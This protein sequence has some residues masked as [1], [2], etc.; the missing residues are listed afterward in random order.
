MT[1]K[2]TLTILALLN[3][4]YAGGKND[5]KQQTEAW[6]M[7]LHKYDYESA[8]NAVLNFAENDTRDYATFPA[9]GLIVKEIR[10]AKKSRNDAISQIIVGISYG[11]T[12]DMMPDKAQALISESTYNE[13]L[14]MDAELFSIKAGTLKQI[15]Q[16]KQKQIE[17]K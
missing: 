2:E 8:R 5:P 1:K 4:F 15:L 10:K 6:H 16:Q 13:W 11:R 7:I 9:V 14:N 17:A 3:A 12:Y